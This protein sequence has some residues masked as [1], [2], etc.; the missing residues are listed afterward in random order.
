MYLSAAFKI[1]GA[2]FLK[3]SGRLFVE[4]LNPFFS[5]S[6]PYQTFECDTFMKCDN[7]RAGQ[8]KPKDVESDG[9]G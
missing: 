1:R 5:R 2:L 3:A 4:V 7:S 9:T 6:I 8:A